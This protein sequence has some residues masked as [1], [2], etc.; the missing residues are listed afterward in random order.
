MCLPLP[1][2]G[3]GIS[4]ITSGVGMAQ[5]S[6]SYNYQRRISAR[7]RDLANRSAFA[8]YG[9][10]NQR[11]FETSVHT[12][13]EMKKVEQDALMARGR[14]GAAV[15]EAGVAGNSVEALFNDFYRQEGEYKSIL[16]QNEKFQRTQSTFEKQAVHLGH[17][18]RLVNSA[19]PQAPDLFGQSLLAFSRAFSVS[20][21]LDRQ[22]HNAGGNSIYF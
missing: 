7:N 3:A 21:D 13:D 16:E 17:E 6:A 14:I 1:I 12:G 18:A 9:A 22:V 19:P 11:D 10:I 20:T 4:L 5:Q 8:Q 2:L 15:A